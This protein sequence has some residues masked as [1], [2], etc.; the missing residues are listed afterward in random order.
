MTL[1]VSFKGTRGGIILA[2]SQETAT[3][4]EGNDFKY[5]VLKNEPEFLNGFRFVIAGGGD[6]TG[7]DELTERF[8]RALSNSNRRTLDGFRTLLESHLAR[9]LKSLEK[10][11][12]R[13]RIELIVAATKNENWEIWRSC[14]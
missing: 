6:G 9:E 4:R 14:L 5:G 1:I 10:N 7:I 3:D 2:D 11:D 12:P 13:A 8:K